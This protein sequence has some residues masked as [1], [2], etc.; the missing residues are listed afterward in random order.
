MASGGITPDRFQYQL[1][2][3][4]HTHSVS[5]VLFCCVLMCV[6]SPPEFCLSCGKMRAA[7][8][9]P[10]FEGGLCQTCKVE[11]QTEVASVFTLSCLSH[12]SREKQHTPSHKLRDIHA[13]FYLP[14][15]TVLTANKHKVDAENSGKRLMMRMIFDQLLIFCLFLFACVC[16]YATRTST[17]RCPTC[18]MTTV[19]S[20]TA[21]CAVAAAR[22]CCAETPT[23]A[24]GKLL[25]NGA[26]T[27]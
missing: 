25:P 23:A 15:L 7:T 21:L 1:E 6:C 12:F 5:P 22:F 19:I 20:R 3:G 26:L 17:W 9:H 4:T 16:V 27:T 14:E 18:T 2:T 10:L 24:G 11:T 8:F 13:G